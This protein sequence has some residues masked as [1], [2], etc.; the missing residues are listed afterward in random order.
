M[1]ENTNIRIPLYFLHMLQDNGMGIQFKWKDIRIISVALFGEGVFA[2]LVQND[3][4]E[5]YSE[6]EALEVTNPNNVDY[7]IV[8]TDRETL[9]SSII[10]FLSADENICGIMDMA[11]A[12]RK[13]G[14]AIMDSINLNII[15][16]KLQDKYMNL[17]MAMAITS[18]IDFY[19]SVPFRSFCKL[20]MDKIQFSID[21]Y[22]KYLNQEW[23]I[24]IV[25][26]MKDNTGE[27]I[28][29]RKSLENGKMDYI[30]NIN[31]IARNNLLAS[32]LLHSSE[33]LNDTDV[34]FAI[35]Q[36][37]YIRIKK[38]RIRKFYDWLE[39]C[40]DVAIGLEFL[41]GSILF[42]NK[43]SYLDGVYLFIVA[44]IQ[45]LIKPGIRIFRRVKIFPVRK[46]K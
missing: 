46:N 14:R 16:N 2:E 18:S 35:N 38:Q 25:L 7:N 9:F 45:L 40:N 27:G 33:F 42:L 3:I 39:I 30:E 43:A 17:R 23:F 32:M 34:N 19:H 5:T 26:A 6:D 11:Y 24:K 10:K 12:S 8:R 37:E 4:I 21:N 44:S 20:R 29:Y 22:E 1:P 31:G 13:I 15:I 28:T 36:Y 41:S